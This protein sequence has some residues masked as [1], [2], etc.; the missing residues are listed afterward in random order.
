MPSEAK[1]PS[2]A[3]ASPS[4][5][6]LSSPPPPPSMDAAEA[7]VQKECLYFLKPRHK[8]QGRGDLLA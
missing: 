6:G 4:L 2:A 8:L 1:R 7:G 5:R 3:K